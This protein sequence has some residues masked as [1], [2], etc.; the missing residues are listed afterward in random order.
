MIYLP[1]HKNT[2][3]EKIQDIS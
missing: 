1:Y 3:D 2:I